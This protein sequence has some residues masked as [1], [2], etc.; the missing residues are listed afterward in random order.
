[1]AGDYGDVDVP[2]PVTVTTRIQALR[3][4]V[5]KQIMREREEMN[6]LK[7]SNSC[8]SAGVAKS[9]QRDLVFGRSVECEEGR[10]R[11]AVRYLQRC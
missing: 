1:M 6:M 5:N 8:R 2:R 4:G 11:N 3:K 7:G 9:L 10:K